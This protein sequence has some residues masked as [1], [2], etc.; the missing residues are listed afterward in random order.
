MSEIKTKVCSKYKQEKPVS[1]FSQNNPN[2]DGYNSH[3]KQCKREYF[4]KWSKTASGIYTSSKFQRR[5][6]KIFNMTR[7]EFYRWY[8][9]QPRKCAY[10]D[11]PE[12][13]IPNI[14]D[15]QI[16]R[17]HRLG[18][19]CMDNK[20]GYVIGNLVLSCLRCNFMKGDFLGYEAMRDIGQR[21]IKPMWEKQL[22]R[23]L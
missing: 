18:L 6:K 22:G 11:L 21:Y 3:C 4:S 7:E 12:E 5:N 15:S 17:M 13:E 14:N 2:K 20:K 9:T 10:C 8:K 23:S 1:E 19:D 16:S